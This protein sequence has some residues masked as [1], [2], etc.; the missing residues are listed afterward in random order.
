MSGWAAQWLVCAVVVVRHVGGCNVRE[1]SDMVQRKFREEVAAQCGS[2][3]E[4]VRIL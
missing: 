1:L 3:G 2:I 4:K